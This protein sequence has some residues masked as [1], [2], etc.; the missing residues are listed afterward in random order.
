MA[1]HADQ[2]LHDG[3]PEAGNK[4][5]EAARAIG[6][7]SYRNYQ[8]YERT[9]SE[10]IN[11]KL[12]DFRA[13]SYQRYQGQKLR[14]RFNVFSYLILSKAMDS[15]NAG[16]DRGGIHKALAQVVSKTLIIS[17]KSD[18]LFPVEEQVE[19]AHHIPNA[20]LQII[21]SAYGHDGFLIESEA[22]SQL[23]GQ[24]LEDESFRTPFAGYK[25][26]K[27]R[28]NGQIAGKGIALPGTE[29]F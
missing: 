23:V 10:S 24:F 16:R 19:L 20:I 4:G 7:L 3:T 8:T 13:A 25:M 1:I 2:T 17:I 26:G 21:D 15:H 18:I 12:D 28:E 11:D 27:P 14:M 22:I 6:M 9:Q 29:K 5:L